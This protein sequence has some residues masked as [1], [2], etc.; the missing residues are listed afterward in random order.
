MKARSGWVVAAKLT[1]RFG[2]NGLIGA[3]TVLREGDAWAIENMVL[4]CR[5]FSREVEQAILALLLNAARKHGAK[6]VTGRYVET[7]KN[8]KF[9]R[10]F[11]DAGFTES[12]PGTFAL[13]LQDEV[14]LPASVKVMAGVEAFDGF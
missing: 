9:T 3:L 8:K 1:D 13:L 6:R 12:E 11:L 2:D 7:A 4:S 5:V 10:F 14:A